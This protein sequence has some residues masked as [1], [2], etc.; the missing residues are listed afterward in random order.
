MSVIQIQMISIFQHFYVTV[1]DDKK[2]AFMLLLFLWKRPAK[3]VFFISY[4]SIYF[5]CEN[6]SISFYE[7]VLLFLPTDYV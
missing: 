4:I 1:V 5:V 2:G 3:Q 6:K 7:F